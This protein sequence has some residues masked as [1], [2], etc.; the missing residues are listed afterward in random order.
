MDKFQTIKPIEY[1]PENFTVLTNLKLTLPETIPSDYKPNVSLIHDKKGSSYYDFGSLTVNGVGTLS[2]NHFSLIWDPNWDYIYNDRAQNFC[3]LVNNS[4]LRA[5]S[6]SVLLYTK[7][8][9]W[10]F[11][12]FPFDV[13]VSEIKA[14]EEG[15]TNWVIRKYDGAK[16]AAGEVNETWVRMT[17]VD[18]LNAGEGY[19]IQSSRYVGTSW[20]DYSGFKINAINNVNK[21]NIFTSNDVNV[22]LNEYQSEFAH[23]RGWNLIGNPYP[24]YYDTRYMDFTAPITV[25]NIKNNTYTAYSPV[26]DSYILCP[27][28]AF[29][30]QCP[31]DKKVINFDKNGRQTNR[32]ARTLD[33]QA[34]TKANN[35]NEVKRI[36]VNLTLSDDKNTDY[37]R[38]VFNDQSSMDYE[39]NKDANKFISPDASVPQL[40]SYHKNVNYAIN[41]RPLA[42]GVVTLYAKTPSKTIYTI[43]LQDEIGGYKIVLEDKEL[44]KRVVLNSETKYMFNANSANNANRFKIYLQSETTSIDNV[45][46][47]EGIE[48]TEGT[49]TISGVKVTE[50]LNK[51]IYIQN[52]KKIIIK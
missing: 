51:G 33:A 2:M 34:M 10:T 44:N 14:T 18:M 36:V 48:N 22:T 23:N 42:E 49:Y 52:G 21:N 27:G 17:D 12:T 13:K 24:S 9:K 45:I 11:V 38:V 50:P 7:N 19:I 3:S 43:A 41:E 1:L 32:T 39:M 37:T 30:V 25:W 46:Q 47:T 8:D 35:L 15:T 28:E 5:D 40:Y 6:V 26:D 4:H 31:V 29:F 20:Q 16:R